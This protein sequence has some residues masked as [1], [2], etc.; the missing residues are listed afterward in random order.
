MERNQWVDD[1]RW[2]QCQTQ[3]PLLPSDQISQ[4]KTRNLKVKK[5]KTIQLNRRWWLCSC[6]RLPTFPFH[7]PQWVPFFPSSLFLA[8]HV[9]FIFLTFLGFFFYNF[10]YGTFS[11]FSL[12][13]IKKKRKRK[14]KMEFMFI[15]I[16]SWKNRKENIIK[17][18]F[19]WF[20][21]NLMGLMN[22]N[23]FL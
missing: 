7:S 5:F 3:T 17:L 20:F 4:N 22:P 13:F 14:R 1:G 6:A 11:G 16:Y 2:I 21:Q 18:W 15:N 10:F 12:G 23:C 19:P 9:I 8:F